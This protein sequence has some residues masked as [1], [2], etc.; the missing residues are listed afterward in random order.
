MCVSGSLVAADS[1]RARASRDGLC[2]RRRCGFRG[3]GRLW[4]RVAP[5][6]LVWLNL[7]QF[8]PRSI[9]QRPP[10]GHFSLGGL[11]HIVQRHLGAAVDDIFL[12]DHRAELDLPLVQA[13]LPRALSRSPSVMTVSGQIP[14]RW[15]SF[16]S[17]DMSRSRSSI[18]PLARATNRRAMTAAED[19]RDGAVRFIG[20]IPNTPLDVAKLAKQL[21]KDGCR[22]GF[23]YEAGGM[24]IVAAPTLIARKPGDRIKTDRRDP[25]KLALQHRLGDLTAVW[26]PDEV[27]EAMRDLVHARI[28]AMMQL[29]RARQQLLAFLLRWRRWSTRCGRVQTRSN[30][31]PVPRRPGTR[32]AAP[33]SGQAA[34]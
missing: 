15:A 25:Q 9:R 11:P 23:C 3:A 16:R 30:P 19:G 5:Q 10:G 33:Q 6:R 31:H 7:A 24:R 27:H 18:V 13:A 28:D 22:L 26:V 8:R 21:S 1:V 34:R 4:G 32:G 2:L 20:T 29:M 17:A 12:S 14:V